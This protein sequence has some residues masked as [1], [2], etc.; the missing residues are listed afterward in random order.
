MPLQ[1]WHA[2]RERRRRL[3]SSRRSDR[4]CNGSD[5]GDGVKLRRLGS[6]DAEFGQGLPYALDLAEV[7]QDAPHFQ[8]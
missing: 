6:A 7:Q 2:A 4:S 8:L 5:A 1:L 3:A